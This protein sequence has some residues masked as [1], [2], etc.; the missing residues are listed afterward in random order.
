[1]T[2]EELKI[3]VTTLEPSRRPHNTVKLSI[4]ERILG[5]LKSSFRGNINIDKQ[6]VEILLASRAL[7]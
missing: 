7:K 4:F 2:I 6:D 3:Y 5:Q 1:M